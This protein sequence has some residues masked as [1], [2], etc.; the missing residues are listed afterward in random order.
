MLFAKRLES[1]KPSATLLVNAKAEEL[2]AQGISVISLAL[3]EP[4]FP[5][6][7]HIREAAKK[8]IDD[9]YT[10]Y[11][12]VTGIPAARKAVTCYY[13]RMYNATI[14][15]KN[16]IITNGGK[17]SLY[18][19]FMVLCSKNDEVLLPV[20]Y[21]TSYPEMIELA[22]AKPVLVQTSSKNG[23]KLQVE[24]LEKAYTANTKVL[25]L[26]SPSNPTG[27]A[28]SQEEL[29]AFADW[30]I[31]KD[32]F[33]ISDEIY[34]QLIYPPKGKASL[35]H[36]F[37]EFPN[38]IAICNGL[39]KS[40]A[41]TGWRLSFTVA[42]PEV[43]KHVT[44]IQ[45]Q[46]TSNVCSI[47]QHALVEALTADYAC[48]EPMREAFIRRLE[49][50][51]NEISTWDGVLCPKPDGAFYL[52]PDFTEILEARG[53]TGDALCAKILE[54]AKVALVPGSAFGAPQCL[55]LSYALAD[56]DLLKALKAIK[57]ILY[58]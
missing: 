21:W 16:T 34:D 54:E 18:N 15:A 19:L 27:V 25:L 12:A 38:N 30:A 36:K 57:E 43:I 41:M 13:E 7:T 39:A 37:L 35:I 3:G 28:Y 23:F 42:S 10:R 2:K 51:Y 14:E 20:P 4:D 33:I 49:L 47:A 48:I 17:Q 44:T 26:N 53:I 32:I 45:S 22:D 8:A 11:T 5:T 50:A 46:A 55:R 24:D 31:S 9:G 56:E 58:K 1:V 40:F 29:D 52:F 6:P